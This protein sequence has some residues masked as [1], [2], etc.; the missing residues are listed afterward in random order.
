MGL[1]FD[2]TVIPTHHTWLTYLHEAQRYLP[3]SRFRLALLVFVNIPVI[4]VLLN[5]IRQLVR[6]GTS[7]LILA[8]DVSHR[9]FLETRHYPP[10]SS[11]LYP[12]LGLWQSMGMTQ[13]HSLSPAAKRCAW[14]RANRHKTAD[15]HPSME[16]YSR[17][18]YLAEK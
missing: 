2:S 8:A 6:L 9:S 18:F 1:G 4:V 3:D 12:S 13:L 16:M 5:V 10:R 7:S 14:L 11:I 17:L 15:L